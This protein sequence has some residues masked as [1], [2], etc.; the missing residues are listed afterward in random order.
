MDGCGA[1]SRI[2]ERRNLLISGDTNDQRD[3]LFRSCGVRR[4]DEQKT[5]QQEQETS[6]PPYGL[7]I[8]CA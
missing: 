8:G 1:V 5:K 2:I 4:D 7:E 6:T 3:G